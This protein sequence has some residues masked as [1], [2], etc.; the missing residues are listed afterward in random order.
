M[1][2]ETVVKGEPFDHK[3]LQVRFDHLLY[4]SPAHGAG[5]A[6][7]LEQSLAA[8]ADAEVAAGQH[9]DALLLVLAD[10]AQ[11]VLPLPLHLPQQ[12]LLHTLPAASCRPATCNYFT[13]CMSLSHS[14]SSK[15]NR[16]KSETV[17]FSVFSPLQQ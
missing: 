4:G 17:T 16:K 11:L 13:C 5:V 9:H 10:A 12:L 8:L 7:V 15:R 6:V 14:L 3:R 2:V 1:K